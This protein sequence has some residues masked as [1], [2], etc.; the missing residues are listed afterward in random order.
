VGA[1]AGSTLPVGCENLRF[2]GYGRPT[3]GPEWARG[4]VGKILLALGTRISVLWQAM[5]AT[6]KR[7]SGHEGKAR[8]MHESVFWRLKEATSIY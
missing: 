4:L 8:G 7:Q 5:D 6:W 1:G 2:R 3:R